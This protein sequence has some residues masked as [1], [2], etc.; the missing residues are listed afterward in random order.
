MITRHPHHKSPPGTLWLPIIVAGLMSALVLVGCGSDTS[1]GPVGGDGSGAARLALSTWSDAGIAYRLTG[2][3]E[4][5]GPEDHTLP[6]VDDAPE[7][8]IDLAVGDYDVELTSGWELLQVDADGSTTAVDAV[9]TSQNPLPFTIEDQETTLLVF[10]FDLGDD[11]LTFGH[12]RGRIVAEVFDDETPLAVA[13]GGVHSCALFGEGEMRCWGTNDFGQLGQGNTTP[14]GATVLPR[15]VS[16]ISLGTPAVQAAA[17]SGHTCALLESGALRCFGFNG[18]GQLG[19][20]HTL[21]VG[22]SEL[23]TDEDEIDLG[24]IAIAIATGSYHSCAILNTGTLRCWGDNTYGQL[25]Y[26][27]TEAIGDNEAPSAAGDIPL[28]EEVLEVA[29]GGGHTCALLDSGNIR[30]WGDN[31]YGQLGL[32]HTDAIGDDEPIADAAGYVELGG[33]ATTIAVGQAHSCAVLES[34]NVRC[35]GLNSSGQLG[36]GNTDTIGDDELPSSAGDIDLG[37][38]A[39]ALTAGD[40]FSCALL[41]SGTIRCWGMNEYGQLGYGHVELIGDDESPSTAGDVPVS[42]SITAINAG[43]EH[44]CVVTHGDALRCWGRNKEGRLGY[45]GDENI[46][47]DEPVSTAGVVP[48]R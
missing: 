8:T 2:T 29:G 35:W 3:F 43:A 41:D 16:P 39:L 26:G 18:Y 24:G 15:D 36:Y 17:G 13:N 33:L 32:G 48:Y 34:G 42:T 12:G 21:A 9:L 22:D 14:I 5:S 44:V 47:D 38:A 4:I 27:N 19:L 31:V 37:A 40:N 28:D 46:G 11:A 7:L 25:G 20:G 23:P 1:S 10:R 30:C 45:G 6:T